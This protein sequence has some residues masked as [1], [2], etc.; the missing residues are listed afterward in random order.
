MAT[1]EPMRPIKAPDPRLTDLLAEKEIHPSATLALAIVGSP[2]ADE[3]QVTLIQ[4]HGALPPDAVVVHLL[5]ADEARSMAQGLVD[6]AN[7]VD[8]AN[9]DTTGTRH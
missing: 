9:V 7:Q 6:A 1:T 2:D 4:A 8:T 5:T 3:K